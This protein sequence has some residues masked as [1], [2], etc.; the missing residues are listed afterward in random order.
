MTIINPTSISGI[1][2]ITSGTQNSIAFYDVNGGSNLSFLVG[3]ASSTGTASQ[4]LQVNGGAYISG[5]IGIGTTTPTSNLHVVGT[6]GVTTAYIGAIND[7]PLAGT[8]NRIINGDMRIDQRNAGASA[9]TGS[10]TYSPYFL[11]RWQLAGSGGGV[12]SVQQSTVA[13]TGFTNSSLITVT[14]ADSSIAA[15]DY[16]QF[17]Q[18]IEGFNFSDLGFGAA[19]AQ[20]VTLSFWVR[21]S[22]TGT[23][24][25]SL[26]NGAA[27]RSYVFTYTV[28]AANT[29]EQKTVTI[30]GDTTGT[31]ATNNTG[32]AIV[33]FSLGVGSTFE[34]TSGSWGAGSFVATSGSVDLVAT[35]G[36]TFYNTG[37]QL[38]TGSVATPFERRSYG[39]ELAL[40]Q[41]YYI[42]LTMADSETIASG[43]SISSNRYRFLLPTPVTMRALPTV[44][45]TGSL[46]FRT[47]GADQTISSM[48]AL[49]LNPNGIIVG[50]AAGTIANGL[51]GSMYA[52]G[53]STIT[54]GIEL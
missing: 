30:A 39:Q 19:G 9:S 13:P 49:T 37:V 34:S 54:L 3:S 10:G 23:F 8:R 50:G 16:Y 43:P 21:S 24:G 7:G 2:S 36:A 48:S 41:R 14:T 11:D 38:E 33:T 35:N 51:S 27:D 17:R 42:S 1:N 40:C 20:S 25:G 31:W 5:N 29:W 26:R 53:T 12:F 28:N 32:G 44:S 45:Y 4:R 6:L 52:S 22:L 46:F 18:T 15:G 47:G